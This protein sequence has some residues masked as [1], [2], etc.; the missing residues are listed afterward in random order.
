MSRWIVVAACLWIGSAA[1]CGG[2]SGVS[3]GKQVVSLSD[4]EISDLCE[5]LV[6]V[7]GPN[8]TIDCGGGVT[9]TIENDTVS[10]CVADLELTATVATSCT[11]TVGDVEDCIKDLAD[12]SDADICADKPFPG[13]CAIW[14][15]AECV[16]AES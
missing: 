5:Y 4:G 12:M 14:F 13:S 11:A 3:S 15:S 9:I 6:E 16:P 10:E 2:G 1:G 7:A 8:R